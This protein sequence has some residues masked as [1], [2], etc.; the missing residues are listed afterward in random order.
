MKI[1]AHFGQKFNNLYGGKWLSV[2]DLIKYFVIF[3]VLGYSIF[4]FENTVNPVYDSKTTK[5]DIR[6]KSS[7]KVKP[8]KKPDPSENPHLSVI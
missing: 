3:L 2:M 5:K 6:P 8:A 7:K 1:Q 4:L